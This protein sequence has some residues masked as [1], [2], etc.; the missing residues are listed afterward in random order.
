MISAAGELLPPVVF[1]SDSNLPDLSFSPLDIFVED[2]ISGPTSSSTQHWFDEISPHLPEKTILIWDA[3]KPH[4]NRELLDELE[5]PGV[6][7]Y[8]LP[9]APHALLSPV[10]NSFNALFRLNYYK[11]DR[12]T[13]EN[14]LNAMKNSLVS[15][16]ANT[17]AKYFEHGGKTSE[18]SPETVSLYLFYEGYYLTP[19][20]ESMWRTRIKGIYT[21][22]SDFAPHPLISPPFRCPGLACIYVDIRTL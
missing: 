9:P 18:E 5:T 4:R 11:R 17:I 13:H 21:T 22:S 3:G 15:I 1:T 2:D 12:S 7:I 20:K 8:S 14:M 16:P 6:R 19:E 10:D